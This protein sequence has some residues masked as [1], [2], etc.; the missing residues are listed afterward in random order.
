MP[1]SSAEILGLRVDSRTTIASAFRALLEQVLEK[2]AG[3]VANDDTAQGTISRCRI[4]LREAR[5]AAA[6]VS[7]GELLLELLSDAL[8]RDRHDVDARKELV[9]VIATV[10]DA[11]AVVAADESSHRA[12]LRRGMDRLST[13]QTVADIRQLKVRLLS[14][15]NG[16]HALMAQR[17][18]QWRKSLSG[19][20]RKIAALEDQLVDRLAESQQDELTGVANRRTLATRFAEFSKERRTFVLAVLDL[21]DFKRVNDEHGHVRGDVVL[22]SVGRLLLAATPP[23]GVVARMGGDE[24]VVLLPDMPLFTAQARLQEM[25]QSIDPELAR[26]EAATTVACSCGVAEYSAGD[27]LNSLLERADQALYDAKRQGKNRVVSKPAA[28]IRDLR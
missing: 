1:Q 4:G 26:D 12:E 21:D 20:E 13:L 18:E 15:V 23:P 2:I 28:Y 9:S 11:V 27:T 10:R 17:E 25:I 16:L 14:E 7:V 8:A 3:L 24:F 5:D 19:F 6:V 22:Q